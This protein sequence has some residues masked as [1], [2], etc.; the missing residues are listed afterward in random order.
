MTGFTEKLFI[1]DKTFIILRISVACLESLLFLHLS[2]AS[3][4]FESSKKFCEYFFA[5]KL[6][7][8]LAISPTQTKLF[9][10]RG[11]EISRLKDGS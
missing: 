3:P 1:I 6:F 9:P 2:F 7:H 11:N 5:L 4:K 10:L 8:Q